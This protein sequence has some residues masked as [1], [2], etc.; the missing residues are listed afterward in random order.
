M[1]VVKKRSHDHQCV[2][3]GCF[4]SPFLVVSQCQIFMVASLLLELLHLACEEKHVRIYKGQNINHQEEQVSIYDPLLSL[5]HVLFW[6][7]FVTFNTSSSAWDLES[8]KGEKT[9]RE[10]KKKLSMSNPVVK[11][12]IQSYVSSE[13]SFSASVKIIKPQADPLSGIIQICGGIVVDL[14]NKRS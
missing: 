12:P 8:S 7:D 10:E 11:A 14:R 9:Y 5:F 1:S 2:N 4:S 6:Y 3:K 13:T